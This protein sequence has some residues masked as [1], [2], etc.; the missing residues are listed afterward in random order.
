MYPA[1]IHRMCLSVLWLKRTRL[2]EK[3]LVV[4]GGWV[5]KR[6]YDIGWS[7]ERNSRGCQNRRGEK[8]RLYLCQRERPDPRRWGNGSGG[9]KRRRRLRNDKEKLHWAVQGRQMEEKPFIGQKVGIW[10]KYKRWRVSAEGL[11]SP[12]HHQWL[13]SGRSGQMWREVSGAARSRRGHG[14]DAR[15]ERNAGW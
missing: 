14:P 13:S 2:L 12:C 9:R 11:P 3:K 15:Y 7:D 1:P 6:L 10:K 8:P 4:E 5:Q